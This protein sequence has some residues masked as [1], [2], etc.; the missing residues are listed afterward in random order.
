M[1]IGAQEWR[2]RTGAINASRG[3]GP[4]II[5]VA[6]HHS[7]AYEL[8]T[9]PPL[10][11]KGYRFAVTMLCLP[12]VCRIYAVIMAALMHLVRREAGGNDSW[13]VD[14]VNCAGE[15]P[16]KEVIIDSYSILETRT[17]IVCWERTLIHSLS[18]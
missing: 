12:V 3:Y 11:W 15:K 10:S 5:K 2:V 6:S 13:N 9:P 7:S 17:I 14:S 1:P 16:E 8:P 4:H 18:S